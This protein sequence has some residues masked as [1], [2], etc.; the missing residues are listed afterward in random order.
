RLAALRIVPLVAADDQFVA[1]LEDADDA[2][3]GPPA[4]LD[5]LDADN[6]A[7]A[8]HRFVEMRSR[9]IDV[10][11]RFESALGGHESVAGRMRLQPPDVQVHFLGQPEAMA[12]NLDELAGRDERFDMPLECGAVVPRNL[13]NLK[14][15]PHPGG[16]MH[17]LPHQREHLVT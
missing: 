3:L 14:E 17:T 2:S 8:V 4:F 7:V 1:A 15:L 6:D 5:P 11:A 10:A 12:P 16:M 13:E 9:N